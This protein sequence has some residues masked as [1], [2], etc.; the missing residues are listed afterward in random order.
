MNTYQKH[1]PQAMRSLQHKRIPVGTRC[2]LWH[3][4][5]LNSYHQDMVKVRR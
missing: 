5:W 3:R 2:S 1:K 4:L